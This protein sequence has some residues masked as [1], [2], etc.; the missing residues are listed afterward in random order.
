MAFP[1]GLNT[2]S[3]AWG[4]V[5]WQPERVFAA[6]LLGLAG[7]EP[8]SGDAELAA[9]AAP[10]TPVSQEPAQPRSRQDRERTA[11]QLRR[12]SLQPRSPTPNPA[13]W[14]CINSPAQEGLKT[15]WEAECTLEPFAMPPRFWVSSSVL[16]KYLMSPRHVLAGSSS[17]SVQCWTRQ[18]PTLFGTNYSK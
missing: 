3:W 10:G 15:P 17:R 4:F 13:A 16:L 11:Q 14:G 12:C 8:L 18:K 6:R 2:A 1:S 7:K 9:A 5:V